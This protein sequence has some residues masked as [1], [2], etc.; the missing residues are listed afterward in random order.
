LTVVTS[1]CT[2]SGDDGGGV[3][4]EPELFGVPEGGGGGGGFGVGDT[5]CG[6]GAAGDAVTE[7]VGTVVRVGTGV[8]DVGEVGAVGTGAGPGTRL[9]ATVTVGG[10]EAGCGAAERGR[11]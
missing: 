2:R 8:S 11:V 3:L 10:E 4:P 5:V 9:G 1:V 7:G 6:I